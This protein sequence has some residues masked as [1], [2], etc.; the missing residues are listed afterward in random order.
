MSGSASERIKLA[1]GGTVLCRRSTA[2][3]HCQLLLLDSCPCRPRALRWTLLL[4]AL[5]TPAAALATQTSEYDSSQT[6]HA[7]RNT[8]SRDW[9]PGSA[10]SLVTLQA[11][12]RPSH[13][14]LCKP[15]DGSQ[16]GLGTLD[17][18]QKR[19]STRESATGWHLADCAL[20]TSSSQFDASPRGKQPR[21]VPP[22]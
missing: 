20:S 3:I 13:I 2:Q 11:N 18:Y 5:H 8:Q 10:G 6:T 22:Q 9:K 1:F 12:K 16:T 19:V 4:S 21:L 17:T 15:H 7:S 14:P